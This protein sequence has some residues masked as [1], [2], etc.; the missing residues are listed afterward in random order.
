M[1]LHY[2]TD[3]E[4]LIETGNYVVERVLEDR[5]IRGKR[6]WRVKFRAFPEPE[7]HYAG[8]VL[9]NQIWCG[10]P[11]ESNCKATTNVSHDQR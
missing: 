4:G 5:V 3:R 8:S 2:Y 11:M 1:P 6:Q 7:W 9:Q 10:T